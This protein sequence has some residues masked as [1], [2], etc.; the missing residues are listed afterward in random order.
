M[1][2]PA[3]VQPLHSASLDAIVEA[4]EELQLHAP[5]AHAPRKRPAPRLRLREARVLARRLPRTLT[6]PG[7][8]MSPHLLIR[9]CHDTACQRRAALPR[10]PHPEHPDNAPIWSAQCRRD[11]CHLVAQ[12]MLPFPMNDEFVGMTEYV[13]ESFHDLLAGESGSL[14][15]SDSSRGSHHPSRECFMAGT[16][17]GYIKSIHEGGAAQRMT[18]TTRSRGM[19]GPH[20]DY[21]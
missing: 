3:A 8:P 11:H 6:I 5:E 9:Q 21:G 17:E 20:L 15:D 18:S 14:S 13:M 16:P 12:P 10:I 7:G 19:Q 2:L 1:L 4:L